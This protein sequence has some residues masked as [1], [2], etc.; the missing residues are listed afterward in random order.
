M[1]EQSLLR[2]GDSILYKPSSLIGWFIAIKTWSM[3]SHIECYIGNGQCI[4][5]RPESVNI[6]PLRNDKYATYILRPTEPF[7]FDK[8]MEWF[9]EEAKGD[10]Y[11]IGGL[12][13]FFVAHNT[14]AHFDK[15]FCSMLAN[16]WYNAGDCYLF[17]KV[18]PT[19]KIAPAQFLQTPHMESVWQAK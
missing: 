19:N 10:S 4:S 6:Y 3:V 9:N 13:G 14:K 7:N 18:Y 5:A 17:N 12:F 1:F 15:E 2:P 11:D 16:L 8:A